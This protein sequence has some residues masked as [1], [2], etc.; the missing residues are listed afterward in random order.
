MPVIVTLPACF[1]LCGFYSLRLRGFYSF[2]VPHKKRGQDRVPVLAGEVD[3]RGKG[4]ESWVHALGPRRE[5]RPI[6]DCKL[7]DVYVDELLSRIIMSHIKA[8][9]EELMSGI[10]KARC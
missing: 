2:L 3:G 1:R 5:H 9:V 4:G 6:K 8:D 10:I 7:V